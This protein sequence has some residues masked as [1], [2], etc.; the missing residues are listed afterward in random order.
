MSATLRIEAV[1]GD[2][3]GLSA[4]I[5]IVYKV[6]GDPEMAGPV[7]RALSQRLLEVAKEDRF[8]GRA[9]RHLL[10]HAAPSDGLKCRRYLLLGLG[11]KDELTLERFRRHLGD[12][13]LECDRLG[14]AN[15]ALPKIGRASCRERV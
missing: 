2:V 15:V 10:W 6:K 3:A 9:G 4:D 14:A 12:A 1:K 11:A 13:L 7:D 8:D 5:G